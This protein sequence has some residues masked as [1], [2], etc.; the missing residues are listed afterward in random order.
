M[1]LLSGSCGE[2]EPSSTYIYHPQTDAKASS[3]ALDSYSEDNIYSRNVELAVNAP[4]QGFTID[5]DGSVWY[6]VLYDTELY[7]SNAAPNNDV[8]PKPAKDAMK[9]TYFGHGTKT[10]P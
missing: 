3:I 7:I 2:S 6:T 10:P 1:M 4:M 5:D 8:V 9:L